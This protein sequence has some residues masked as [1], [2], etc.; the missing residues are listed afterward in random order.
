MSLHF[1]PRCVFWLKHLDTRAATRV[2]L[3]YKDSSDRFVGAIDP[4]SHKS[5]HREILVQSTNGRG[6]VY[7]CGRHAKVPPIC[8][9]THLMPFLRI[10]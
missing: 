7:F 2:H 3:V 6:L 9:K 5:A 10:D 1:L 4:D 8:L